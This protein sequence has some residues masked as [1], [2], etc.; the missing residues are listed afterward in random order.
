MKKNR[1]KELLNAGRLVIGEWMGISDPAVVEIAA[2]AGYDFVAIDLEHSMI[3]LKTVENMVRAAEATNI[4]A[5]VRVPSI[6]PKMILRIM[7]GGADGVVLPHV[8]SAED[9]KI[10]VDA[11]KYYP[12]G[13]RGISAVARSAR[14]FAS[15][16]ME[17]SRISNKETMIVA[18]IEESKA[19]ENIE[20]ILSVEG[21][22]VAFI[23]PADLSSSLGVLADKN[24]P[25][26]EEAVNKV[27]AVGQKIKK[28]KIGIAVFHGNYN[29][30]VSDLLKKGIRFVTTTPMDSAL[31]L[32]AFREQV[33]L[34]REAES[35]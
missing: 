16:F 12:M 22:D 26:I 32:R 5:L 24:H 6:D 29:P 20:E 28:A 10:A 21:L 15:D 30:P 7:D 23:G 35:M 14:Y 1:A 3:D 2:L 34:V 9:V 4:T 13:H 33:R 27:I 17:Y 8:H 11:I 31:L 25:K 18:M 19:I